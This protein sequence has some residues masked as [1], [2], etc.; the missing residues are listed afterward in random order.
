MLLKG[1]KRRPGIGTAARVDFAG[2]EPGA[3]E[4]DLNG[5]LLLFLR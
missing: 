5:E 4:G 1:G 3:I 2:G